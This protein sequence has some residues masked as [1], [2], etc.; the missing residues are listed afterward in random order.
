M[1]IIL[2]TNIYLSDIRMEGINFQ[3]LQGFLKKTDSTLVLPRLVREEVVVSYERLLREAV[4]K[5][6]AAWSEY[7]RLS[8]DPDKFTP[9]DF[10]REARDLRGRLRKGPKGIRFI[11]LKEMT[12][13]DIDEVYL[14]GIHRKAPANEKGEELRDVMLWLL[15]VVYSKKCREGVAFISSD[16]GFWGTTGPADQ[17]QKDIEESGAKIDV[18]KSIQDF[19]T[20]KAPR[21]TSV[22]KDAQ[23]ELLK[24]TSLDLV[25]K[26]AIVESIKE[27]NRF[28]QGYSLKGG[29]VSTLK[30]EFLSGVSYQIDNRI[31]F[32]ELNYEIE[33][34]CKKEERTFNWPSPSNFQDLQNTFGGALG[35]QLGN[36]FGAQALPPFGRAASDPGISSTAT[37]T[38]Y[39]V[40][41]ICVLFV[42]VRDGQ[43][44]ETE[45]NQIKIKSSE[46][47]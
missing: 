20:S 41:C 22:S 36:A 9:P 21:P 16:R 13:V 39:K 35:S 34:L 44:T 40:K 5:V 12:G 18:Y 31:Q 37:E 10:K 17:I 15:T 28:E 6:S 45:V 32:M 27:A 23:Q 25:F 2:D 29:E 42:R 14:R 26:S 19:I 1:H 38:K 30:H 11:E 7:H 33:F 46:L 8:L 3:N 43:V 47:A 4:R 24:R